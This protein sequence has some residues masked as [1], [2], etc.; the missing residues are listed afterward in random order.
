MIRFATGITRLSRR[1]PQ[2]F[3]PSIV[4]LLGGVAL[5]GCSQHADKTSTNTA[6]QNS[7]D[8]SSPNKTVQDS[9]TVAPSAGTAQQPMPNSGVQAFVDPVTGELR[10]PTD[11]ERAAMAAQAAQR[12]QAASVGSSATSQPR[13]IVLPDG[14]VAVPV[15]TTTETLQACV[16]KDGHVTVDHNCGSRAK[17]DGAKR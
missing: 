9:S 13:E 16:E 6:S 1:L 12:K 14:S 11:A 8:T 7:S 17:D 5:C 10:A 3:Y 15:D 4:A 2:S